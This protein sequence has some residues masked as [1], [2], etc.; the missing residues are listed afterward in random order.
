MLEILRVIGLTVY[1]LI[2]LYAIAGLCLYIYNFFKGDFFN[3][4]DGCFGIVFCFAIILGELDGL[5]SYYNKT[6]ERYS[7]GYTS[8]SHHTGS[9]SSYSGSYGNGSGSASKQPNKKIQT[10]NKVAEKTTVK[11]IRNKVREER[12]H[13]LY[14]LVKN[15]ESDSVYPVRVVDFNKFPSKYSGCCV[16]M[17]DENNEKY[18]IPIDLLDDA[19]NDG[20]RVFRYLL[21]NRDWVMVMYGQQE[22]LT[23]LT[24]SVHLYLN[25]G[26]LIFNY[27][28]YFMK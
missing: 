21:H 18:S 22:F 13:F 3:D 16:L 14:M 8:S 2:G 4:K 1:V 28:D 7:T 24:D 10:V 5:F 19:E 27:D 11:E 12:R 15:Q 26:W 25:R 23:V 9:H 20:L 17:L 6:E